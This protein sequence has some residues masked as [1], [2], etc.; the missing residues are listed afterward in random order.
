MTKKME[1]ENF[2]SAVRLW[3]TQ[4]GTISTKAYMAVGNSI[5]KIG[6]RYKC[7]RIQRSN[8]DTMKVVLTEVTTLKV[9]NINSISSD[10]FTIITENSLYYVVKV[11]NIPEG[12]VHLA[13]IKQVPQIGES[14][15]CSKLE[16]VK[17]QLHMMH[18]RTSK[19]KEVKSIKELYKLKTK[20]DHIYICFPLQ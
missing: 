18:C 5:P 6:Q 10:V 11:L 8:N 14:I 4:C 16:F 9:I 15:F 2:D 1:N 7:W 12:K 3:Q 17:E 20:D 19:I 13:V